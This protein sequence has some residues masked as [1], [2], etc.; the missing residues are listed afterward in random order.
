MTCVICKNGVTSP[1]KVTVTLHRDEAT[2]IFKE[3]PAEVCENCS[4]YYLSEKMTGE[5]LERAERAVKN[6]P[7]VEIQKYAA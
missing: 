4:E 2:I 7:M 6:G 3:V 1:G 5:L